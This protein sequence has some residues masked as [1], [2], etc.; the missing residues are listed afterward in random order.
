MSPIARRTGDVKDKD[1]DTASGTRGRATGL[2]LE[3]PTRAEMAMVREMKDFI[4]AERA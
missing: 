2:A 4:F 3:N 1:D